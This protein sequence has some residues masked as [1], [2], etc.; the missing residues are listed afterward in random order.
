MRLEKGAPTDKHTDWANRHEFSLINRAGSIMSSRVLR[1]PVGGRSE[2]WPVI[3]RS[4]ALF[5]SN[6]SVDCLVNYSVYTSLNVSSTSLFL[7]PRLQ[8][9]SGEFN[10]MTKHH[11]SAGNQWISCSNIKIIA[12]D[13][14][15]AVCRLCV[16]NPIVSCLSVSERTRWATFVLSCFFG[17]RPLQVH[18]RSECIAWIFIFNSVSAKFMRFNFINATV[19]RSAR[20]S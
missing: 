5:V 17:P 18:R 2:K 8:R 13:V 14:L 10:W 9:P 16:T 12:A 1:L 19:F 11:R 7:R 4:E 20:Q 15:C 6:L 3:A